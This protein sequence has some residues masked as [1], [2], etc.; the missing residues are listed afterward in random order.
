[1]LI[2]THTCTRTRTHTYTQVY[3]SIYAEGPMRVLCFAEEKTSITSVDDV[4]SV[5][6]MAIRC[7]CECV[8]VCVRQQLRFF[9]MPTAC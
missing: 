1:M 7:V 9:G 4:N 3:V 8:S 2:P 5:L 6:N